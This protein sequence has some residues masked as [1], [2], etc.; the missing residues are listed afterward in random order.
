MAGEISVKRF[1]GRMIL[2]ISNG[3]PSMEG[4]EGLDN[5]FFF[6]GR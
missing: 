3:I 1:F 5:N 6:L 2:R 4:R